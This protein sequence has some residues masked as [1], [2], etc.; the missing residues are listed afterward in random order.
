MKLKPNFHQQGVLNRYR[1]L[2]KR[3]SKKENQQHL[4][5]GHQVHLQFIAANI[6]NLHVV[7][8]S[9]TKWEIL[10]YHFCKHY[11]LVVLHNE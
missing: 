4:N 7:F 2:R 1:Y 10:H 11:L 6:V 3:K 5:V 9:L 8:L